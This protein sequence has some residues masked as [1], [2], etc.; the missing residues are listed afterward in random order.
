M[1]VRDFLTN[2]IESGEYRLNIARA[3]AEFDSQLK[4]IY[5]L[6]FLLRGKLDW[7]HL[8]MRIYLRKMEKQDKLLYR[9]LYNHIST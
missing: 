6:Q 1:E 2:E 5:H 4:C 3:L 8:K 9:L 7:R